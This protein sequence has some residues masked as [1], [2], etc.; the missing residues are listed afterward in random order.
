MNGSLEAILN[1][2]REVFAKAYPAID[3]DAETAKAKAWLVSNPKNRK[4]NLKRYL[5][6]WFNREQDRWRSP[7]GSNST[8][9]ARPQKPVKLTLIDCQNC[10]TPTPVSEVLRSD[11]GFC[12]KCRPAAGEIT[13]Q[14]AAH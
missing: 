8:T 1:S 2:E 11:D 9:E 13:E 4:S 5:N 10:G 14:T 7:G 3:L 6:G 12:K